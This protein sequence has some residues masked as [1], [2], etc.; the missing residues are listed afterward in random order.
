MRVTL[1]PSCRSLDRSRKAGLAFRRSVRRW[2]QRFSA[3]PS[4]LLS[5]YW[6][7]LRLGPELRLM[8]WPA[9]R[10]RTTPG[11]LASFGRRRSMNSLADT[12]RSPRSLRAIQ[13]RPLAMVWLLP[14]T[15]TAWENARTAGSASMTL[16]SAW[17]FLIMSG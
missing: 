10:Y 11:T 12:S 4:L 9:R 5:T 1:A 8:S 7:W 2:V 16:A 13:K 3:G 17:C 6:Y 15:P 14:V